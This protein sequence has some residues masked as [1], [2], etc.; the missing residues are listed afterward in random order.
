MSLKST[1][2]TFVPAATGPVRAVSA[3]S[4]EYGIDT[5][6]GGCAA[7]I[8]AGNVMPFTFVACPTAIAA[9]PPQYGIG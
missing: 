2:A 5:I 9:A 4:T 6:G 8:D 7:I 1:V 3:A